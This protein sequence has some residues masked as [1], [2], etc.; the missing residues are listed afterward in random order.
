[1]SK[2]LGRWGPS[3]TKMPFHAVRSSSLP[4]LLPWRTL[5]VQHHLF[6]NCRFDWVRSLLLWGRNSHVSVI[7]GSCT[8]GFTCIQDLLPYSPVRNATTAIV[9]RSCFSRLIN[10]F[11]DSVYSFRDCVHPLL[12]FCSRFRNHLHCCWVWQGKE[13][14]RIDV[15]KCRQC[16]A[17]ISRRLMQWSTTWLVSIGM[18]PC[19]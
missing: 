3:I 1:M 5:P 18:S 9:Q 10:Q 8:A 14:L 13:R 4:S 2:V 11:S 6:S 16:I 17:T 12:V 19:T 7:Y 15:V